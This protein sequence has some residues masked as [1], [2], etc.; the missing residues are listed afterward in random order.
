V[1]GLTFNIKRCKECSTL[2]PVEAF[3]KSKN[4]KDGLR[5]SCKGCI[6]SKSNAWYDTNKERT[7]VTSRAW[8]A[9]NKERKAA[10]MKEWEEANRERRATAKKKWNDAN[11]ERKAILDKKW[12]KANRATMA[13]HDAKRRAAKLQRTPPWVCH[14]SI[15]QV[16]IEAQKL[17]EETGQDYHVDHIIP[18]QGKTVSGLHI[19]EN[20]QVITATEN[21]SKG[22]RYYEDS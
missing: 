20:L 16:Y 10:T 15:K 14:E 21:L 3:H 5:G 2:K 9:A 1:L 7:A 11:K 8:Y 22:N 12:R 17:K 4:N 13:A 18:L 6:N 19:A